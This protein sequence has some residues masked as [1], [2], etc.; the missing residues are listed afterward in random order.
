MTTTLEPASPRST[1]VA[2]LP[3][4]WLRALVGGIE[5]ALL[6]WLLVVVPAVAAYVATAAAPLLG[7]A[8]WMDAAGL[9][10][11]FWLLGHG[12]TMTLGQADVTLIP[13]GLSVLSGAL[14]YGATRRARLTD[15]RPACYTVA[16]FVVAALLLSLTV[17]GPVHRWRVLVIT[18]LVAGI[19]AALALRRAGA[20]APGV[21]RRAAAHVP[22]VVRWGARDAIRAAL[23]VVGLATTVV[24]IG[25]L[26]GVVT[27]VE[28]HEALA[29]GVLGTVALVLLQLLYLP[30]LVVWAV[31][32]LAGPGFAVGAGTVFSP[33]EVVTAPLPAIPMLGA[34]PAPGSPGMGWVTL[35]VVAVGAYRGWCH[36][37]R[38]LAAPW[39][40]AVLT[41]LVMA[42]G[43]GSV[44]ALLTHLATGGIGPGRMTQVGAET[45]IVGLMV[46]CQLALGAMVVLLAA[47]PDVHRVVRL[48]WQKVRQGFRRWR[49]SPAPDA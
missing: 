9:A 16:G 40:Q 38:G 24:L 31:A 44:C 8:N 15:W 6:G 34:L 5:A 36:H 30:T 19:G 20:D 18:L 33:T 14:V 22:A 25:L 13:G 35:S 1:S 7:E 26:R 3:R 11:K 21:L 42:V 2:F 17:A 27:I 23:I 43:A 46:A 32:W 37:R 41:G 47:H 12:G 48:G 45:A 49:A 28:L 4:Y 10:T 29:P 39:W